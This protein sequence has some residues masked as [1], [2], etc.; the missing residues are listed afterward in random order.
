M[1]LIATMASI[2]ITAITI[3]ITSFSFNFFT[4]LLIVGHEPKLPT[5]IRQ[6]AMAVIS[7]D[8]FNVWI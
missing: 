1:G 2:A 3:T 4:I 6:D 7:M 8:D 5:S